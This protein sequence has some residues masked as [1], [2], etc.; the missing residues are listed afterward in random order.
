MVPNRSRWAASR[1]PGA[2]TVPTAHASTRM[3]APATSPVTS[4]PEPRSA[5][6]AGTARIVWR[7]PWIRRKMISVPRQ[8]DVELVLVSKSNAVARMVSG[9]RR[10]WGILNNDKDKNKD[11][12][13]ASFK[14]MIKMTRWKYGNWVKRAENRCKIG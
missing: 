9:G 4:W 3:T 11:K 5:W 10:F 7:G 13:F 2:T 6:M 12:L 8:R 1:A 14:E